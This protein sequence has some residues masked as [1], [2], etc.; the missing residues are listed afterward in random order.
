MGRETLE[1]PG[2]YPGIRAHCERNL[3]HLRFRLRDRGLRAESSD[4]GTTRPQAWLWNGLR[5]AA[6]NPP[7]L[8]SA[9]LESVACPTV[10]DCFAAGTTS[11][12]SGPTTFPL[13]APLIERFG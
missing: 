4:N 10:S 3:V 1:R 2:D 13:S 6:Q 7:G 8:S 5:W 12:D 9:S 11:T